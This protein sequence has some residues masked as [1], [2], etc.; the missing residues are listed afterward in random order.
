M[1]RI[2]DYPKESI[3]KWKEDKHS[4]YYNII[5]EEIYPKKPILYTTQSP[6]SYPILHDYIV[7]TTWRRRKNKY[8][9][10]C[11]INYVNNK[12]VYQI[13]FGNN[14]CKQVISYKTFSNAAFL[15]LQQINSETKTQ[16]SGIL[17]FGLQLESLYQNQEKKLVNEAFKSTLQ[18]NTLKL[19]DEASK[20]TLQKRAKN[21]GK[22]L[23]D[24]F[25]IITKQHYNSIDKPVLEDLKFSVNNHRYKLEYGDEDLIVKKQKCEAVLKTVDQEHIAQHAYRSLANIENELSSQ[26]NVEMECKV[27]ITTIKM[28]LFTEINQDEHSNINDPEI[29]CEVVSSIGKVPNLVEKEI[30]NPQQPVINLRI[31]DHWILDEL[32]V[33][34]YITD[35]LWALVLH[36]I[37]EN[38][39][40][41]DI[42]REI[43]IYKIKKINVYFEFWQESQTWNYIS[44]MGKDKLKFY[45]LYKA[46]YNSITDPNKFKENTKNWLK[47]FFIPSTGTPDN[48]VQDLYQPNNLTPYIYVFV[49]HIH[50]FM[51]KHKKWSGNGINQKS[52]IIQ[53]LEF[54]NQKLY[55]NVNSSLGNYKVEKLRIKSI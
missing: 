1:K 27:R 43:I 3:I 15:Y 18:K 28:L 51:E 33:I 19:V 4:F 52:A 38:G 10:Q 8:T 40:Y 5:K 49:Y 9:V 48:L 2:S 35:R 39:F 54:E 17:L 24:D 6:A 22:R 41:N 46:I 55:Y 16:T 32:Y 25:A 14:F 50:E 21:V 20:S 47:L 30:P 26:I 7:Q 42:A 31:L 53:I 23:L 29:V 37:E 34:L 13:A 45:N 44:L 36:E 12:P 11:S